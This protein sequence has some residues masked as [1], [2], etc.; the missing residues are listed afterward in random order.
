MA[1]PKIIFNLLS[2]SNPNT[3]RN[4]APSPKEAILRNP[5]DGMLDEMMFKIIQGEEDKSQVVT[6]V[7]REPNGQMALLNESEMKKLPEEKKQGAT[8]LRSHLEELLKMEK[9]TLVKEE[10]NQLEEMMRSTE[11]GIIKQVQNAFNEALREFDQIYLTPAIL[12]EKYRSGELQNHKELLKLIEKTSNS[13]PSF[14]KSS[15]TVRMA[16][17]SCS[18]MLESITS[19]IKALSESLLGSIRSQG[20]SRFSKGIASIL[21][22]KLGPDSFCLA[23]RSFAKA[24]EKNELFLGTTSGQIVKLTKGE[25]EKLKVS[26]GKFVEVGSGLFKEYNCLALSPSGDRLLYSGCPN[27]S[28]YLMNTENGEEIKKWTRTASRNGSWQ[29]ALSWARPNE[30]ACF[31]YD[32]TIRVFNSN[33]SFTPSDSFRPFYDGVLTTAS[34][35][36][37]PEIIICGDS[38]GRIFLFST[39]SKKAELHRD[40]AHKGAV[41]QIEYAEKSNLIISI[42]ATDKCLMLLRGESLEVIEKIPMNEPLIGFTRTPDPDYVLILTKKCLGLYKIEGKG[43]WRQVDRKPAKEFDKEEGDNLDLV[44]L[45]ELWSENK[46]LVGDVKGRLWGVHFE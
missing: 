41:L 46:C 21:P 29:C 30:F 2:S 38:G 28:I 7:L 16:I 20:F 45:K 3:V 12:F 24:E 34:S 15:N 33:E 39:A 27:Q 35:L 42:G 11:E 22:V 8:K 19:Q 1:Q 17:A 37:S 13:I 26:W 4:E 32:G 44:C 40:W 9:D 31:Y 23:K 36:A 5:N 25:K 43:Q 14:E 6:H 10:R 18:V